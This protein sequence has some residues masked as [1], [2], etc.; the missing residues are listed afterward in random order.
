MTFEYE[1]HD[2]GRRFSRRPKQKEDC[3]VRALVIATGADYDHAYDE[4]KSRG[5]DS[6]RRFPF[7]IITKEVV[8][9][10][11]FVWQ[12]F[13]DGYLLT[14]AEF[15]ER[16]SA[17]TFILQMKGHV[18]CVKDGVAYDTYKVEDDRLIKGAWRIERAR[19]ARRARKKAFK[20]FVGE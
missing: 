4:L 7:S 16:Y 10:H 6:H 3:T 20:P 1:Y 8:F 13:E 11:V 19:N 12:A 14:A 2:G 15:C 5:R 9:G 17:G 18:M